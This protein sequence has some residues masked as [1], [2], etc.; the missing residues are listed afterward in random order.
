[1]AILTNPRAVQIYSIA[2]APDTSDHEWSVLLL[3][4][5]LFVLFLGMHDIGFFAN[6][7]YDTLQLIWPEIDAD[8]VMYVYFFP[9]NL[10]QRSS[11][12]GIRRKA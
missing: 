12:A 7:Q 9:H 1:M 6:I 8:T 10:L 3:L 2:P 4:L 5:F 11:N